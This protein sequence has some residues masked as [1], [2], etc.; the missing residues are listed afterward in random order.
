MF[1]VNSNTSTML[2]EWYQYL[3]TPGIQRTVIQPKMLLDM[4]RLPTPLPLAFIPLFA[5]LCPPSRLFACPAPDVRCGH[6]TGFT[7][8]REAGGET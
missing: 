8:S 6:S 5:V 4:R 7:E 3:S 1:S 2:I